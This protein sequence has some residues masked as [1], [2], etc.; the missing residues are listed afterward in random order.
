[1]GL[2]VM[3]LIW[4][5][6]VSG[7]AG[8][9]QADRLSVSHLSIDRVGW[10]TLDVT[11]RFTGNGLIGGAGD[12]V[13]DLVTVTLFDEAYDTLYSGA[14]GRIAVFDENLGNAERL[15]LE[16][17][18]YLGQHMACDQQS[19]SASPKRAQASYK[20]T[21]PQD[22]ERSEFD[23]A[24]IESRVN[25][26]RQV[27]GSEDWQRFEPSSRKE[28][29]VETWV[30]GQPEAR[31]RLPVA[32]REQRFI[33]PRYSGYRDFR[34]AIQSSMLDADSAAV[35]FDLFVRL[36]RDALPVASEEIVLRQKSTNERE[37]EMQ[38][39]VER[40]SAQVLNALEGFFGIR[41]AYVFVNDWSYTSLD[42]LYRAEFE[43][44]WQDGFRGSW[45]DLTGEMQVRS[46][47][48]LG[49]FVLKRASERAE[50]RWEQRVGKT[51]LELD[52]LYP[53][54]EVLPPEDAP[55]FDR[56]QQ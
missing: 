40:A 31:L 22:P 16:V 7:L 8:C 44:H 19:L 39:L 5:A 23:R 45:S 34:Y 36:S 49:T 24:L 14:Q 18:G 28:I 56:D 2:M 48:D 20:V 47:G 29:F 37:S 35:H 53:E 1:M 9:N 10:D 52:H 51:V 33:L 21:F 41:R 55:E 11:A 26:E 3:S 17:C 13:P 27:F 46:D 54:R 50:E 4:M 15:L 42:R 6:A 43:L 38:D 25:L 30:E 12:I 32:R